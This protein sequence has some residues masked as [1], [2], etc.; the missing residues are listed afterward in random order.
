MHRK[1]EHVE[2]DPGMCTNIFSNIQKK[3]IRQSF[4]LKYEFLY[5]PYPME[6]L[7]LGLKMYYDRCFT[8]DDPEES[9]KISAKIY[10]HFIIT[11]WNYGSIVLWNNHMTPPTTV[12]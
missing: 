6:L 11:F 2:L 8:F 4:C 3:M 12:Y 7:L 9:I 10:C 1:S 5:D